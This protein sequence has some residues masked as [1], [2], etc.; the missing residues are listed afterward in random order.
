MPANNNK[1]Q[2]FVANSSIIDEITRINIIFRWSANK[3]QPSI[4][5]LNEIASVLDVDVKDLLVST[6]S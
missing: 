6:K 4:T 1:I 3:V 2:S 5:Q